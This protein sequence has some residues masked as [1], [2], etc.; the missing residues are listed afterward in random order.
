MKNY[1]QGAGNL[2]KEPD[3]NQILKQITNCKS[4]TGSSALNK[5]YKIL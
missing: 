3:I 1:P 4:A 2:V 5:K